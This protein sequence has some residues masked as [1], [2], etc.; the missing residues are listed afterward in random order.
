M[1]GVFQRGGLIMKTT[2][3]FL[4]AIAG[5]LAEPALADGTASISS[6]LTGGYEIKSVIDLPNDEQ[7]CFT[8]VNPPHRP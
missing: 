6:L 3:W 5:L 8:Q 2:G 1:L 4:F 7:A